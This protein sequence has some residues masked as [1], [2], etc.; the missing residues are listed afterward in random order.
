MNNDTSFITNVLKVMSGTVIVQ[1]IAFVTL[2]I[3]TRFFTPQMYGIS[4][5]FISIS[6]ILGLI[7]C[8]RYE[9]A[10][11][12]PKKDTR[13]INI[14]FIALSFTLIITFLTSLV[15]LF[16]GD[17]FITIFEL[18]EIKEYLWVIPFSVF[19]TG[20]SSALKYWNSR[21][22]RFG[23]EAK[24]L[25]YS[26]V[27]TQILKLFIGFIGIASSLYLI[28]AGLIGSLIMMLF[29]LYIIVTKEFK[30]F[31]KSFSI[32]AIRLLIIKYKQYPLVDLWG[33]FFNAF[34]WQL[35][36]L[37]LGFFFSPQIV[38]FWVLGYTAVRMPM[39]LI[40][41]S[42]GKVFFQK[43]SEEKHLGT[44]TQT[45]KNIF[46]FLI[47]FGL[48][49]M[50]LI[51]FIGEDLFQIIFGNNWIEAGIYTQILSSWLFFNFVTS[52]T[53]TLFYTF[54]KIKLSLYIH[55]LI[56]ITRFFSLL[57]GGLL[58][59]IYLAIILYSITGTLTYGYTSIISLKIANIESSFF[60]KLLF[61]HTVFFV[62]II[63][64][65]IFFKYN[66]SV[67]YFLISSILLVVIYYLFYL[68]PNNTITKPIFLRILK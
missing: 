38:G 55:I 35:P 49:V 18:Y 24:A 66:F 19:L 51:S 6:T 12:I 31:Y 43:I 30:L 11:M 29:F 36:I 14:F 41:E 39:T 27:F 26:S 64:L 10:I 21:K 67:I 17:Y 47:T 1:F 4:S 23:F 28:A 8:L 60:F 61:K 50:I 16:F 5:I 53:S 57:I 40:G 54:D 63:L 56:F 45:I 9:L 3:I 13:A 62:P 2:P 52:A 20:F 33:S 22:K 48:P 34:S 25:I 44:S 32:K 68:F 58:N 46:D 59:D 15:V 7:A 37:M 65:I 42:V